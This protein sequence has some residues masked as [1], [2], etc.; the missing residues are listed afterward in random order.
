MYVELTSALKCCKQ[1]RNIPVN[2]DLKHHV[3]VLALAVVYVCR[4][5]GGGGTSYIWHS[6]DLRAECM[7]PFSALPGIL[8]AQIIGPL[9]STKS[10]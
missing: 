2:A 4:G 10:I 6:T 9:F 5:G 1:Y 7:A 8:L 3:N